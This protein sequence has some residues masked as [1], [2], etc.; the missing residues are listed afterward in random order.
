MQTPA[1]ELVSMY[2]W[3]LFDQIDNVSAALNCLSFSSDGLL[4][5]H[6]ALG[7]PV[8]IGDTLSKLQ[9]IIEISMENTVKILRW[10]EPLTF[11]TW[12]NLCVGLIMECVMVA[13]YMRYNI[14]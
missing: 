13:H 3:K 14:I 12:L 8:K 5:A 4:L 9:P 6:C 2:S 11:L 7:L 1:H 10:E